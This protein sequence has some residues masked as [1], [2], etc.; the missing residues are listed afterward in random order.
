M[1]MLAGCTYDFDQF[2]DATAPSSDMH[3]D[4]PDGTMTDMDVIPTPDADMTITEPD[5]TM[6]GD[7]TG[8]MEG[9]EGGKAVGELCAADSE[10]DQGMCHLGVCVAPCDEE[11]TCEE[12]TCQHTGSDTFACITSCDT[13]G[14]ACDEAGLGCVRAIYREQDPFQPESFVT[15]LMCAPDE[16]QDSVA[17]AEDNCPSTANPQQHDRDHDGLG[18]A[19]DTEPLCIPEHAS[20]RRT[21]EGISWPATGFTSASMLAGGLL[22]ISG[23][24]LED[25]SRSTARILV[26]R[27]SWQSTT[28]P[29]A[30]YGAYDM[31]LTMLGSSDRTFTMPGTSQ[32]G[33]RQAGRHLSSNGEGEL[34]QGPQLTQDIYSPVL[35]TTSEGVIVVAGYRNAADSMSNTIVIRTWNRSTQTWN[36]VQN[37]G[38]SGHPEVYISRQG[39][40]GVRVYTGPDE[41]TEGGIKVSRSVSLNSQGA[42]QSSELLPM[43][44]S[45]NTVNPLYLETP[46]G[47]ELIFD[48]FSGQSFAVVR[49]ENMVTLETFS[50]YAFT[51]DV[52]SSQLVALPESMG[53]MLVGMSTE[54]PG[55]LKITEFSTLCMAPTGTANAP[56]RDGDTID[57]REDNCVGVANPEQ[58]DADLDGIG[59]AC[60]EDAD[61]DGIA[62]ALDVVQDSQMQLVSLALDTDND[63]IPNAED[64][65]DDNDGIVD[66]KDRLPLDTDNDGIPNLRDNDDDNDGYSNLAEINASTD[67]YNA[68]DYPGIGY[69]SFVVA[70]AQGGRQ[71]KWGKIHDLEQAKQVVWPMPS[72]PHKPR[73]SPTGLSMV[74]LDGTPGDTSSVVWSQLENSALPEGEMPSATAQLDLMRG[75]LWSVS[76]TGITSEPS[77]GEM[78]TNVYVT[79]AQDDDANA[80]EIARITT[81]LDEALGEYP[82]TTLQNEFG[83]Y[84]DLDVNQ[85]AIYFIGAPAMCATCESAYR[86]STSPHATVSQESPDLYGNMTGIAH[87]QNRVVVI[88][89]QKLYLDGA[90]VQLPEEDMLV[91]SAVVLGGTSLRIVLSGKTSTDT[92]YD[93]WHFDG[94]RG[95]WSKLLTQGEDLI[96]LDWRQ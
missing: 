7:M 33:G 88:K 48:R 71:V 49:T 89:D 54:Q 76:M 93:L 87:Y 59:D 4:Q 67:P 95:A 22:E 10:C 74:A 81:T 72:E 61:N 16:D 57:D 84:K 18:D 15:Y 52:Q 56:D 90:E 29:D 96:E 30:L 32:D 47:F 41:L 21:L 82:V 35:G 63:G 6:T 2:S 65:D 40:G 36:S 9:T 8:D 46:G 27:Q 14:E 34:V 12:G 79:R 17:D 86:T 43:P 24:T 25:G 80:M 42:V 13:E 50:D 91:E 85:G 73:F 70:D 78:L 23:G 58:A 19:C 45:P 94:K 83:T 28:R 60:D 26:D 3:M 62:N 51:V 5:A 75:A 20:G 38:V 53:M 55:T 31:A 11:N 69:I 68:L 92:S 66:E 1:S 64:P 39:D 44:S 77:A 37:M